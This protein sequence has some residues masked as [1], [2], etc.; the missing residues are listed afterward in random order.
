MGLGTAE[1]GP[2]LQHHAVRIIERDELLGARLTQ[3]DL[4]Q[5]EFVGLLSLRCV[6]I[7]Y[8]LAV[9]AIALAEIAVEWW[10]GLGGFVIGGF[11]HVR[12][13]RDHK[14]GVQCVL[15]RY[16]SKSLLHLDRNRVADWFFRLTVER[17]FK[18][19]GFLGIARY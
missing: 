2:V 12:S 16:R 3:I 19:A 7:P 6:A 13:V 1:L 8:D 5:L 10:S 15:E 14:R 9:Q 17:V 4:L 18:G 11:T